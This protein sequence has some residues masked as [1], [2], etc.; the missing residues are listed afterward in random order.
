[1]LIL[2]AITQESDVVSYIGGLIIILIVLWAIVRN[3]SQSKKIIENQEETIRLLK[4][5]AGEPDDK[6]NI[7]DAE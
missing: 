3:A 4:K 1:M 2:Q 5:I 6:T 7:D